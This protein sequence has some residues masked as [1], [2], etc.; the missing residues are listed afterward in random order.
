MKKNFGFGC[1]RLPMIDDIVDREQFKKM[2]D[3]FIKE[4]FNYFDTARVYISGQSEKEIK[5]CLTDRYPRDK[6]ILT[7]KLTASCFQKES[8]I[9]PFFEEQLALTGVEYFDYYL[10]HALN[11]DFYAK[12]ENCNAFKVAKELKKNGKIKHIG[13]SF[14]DKADVLDKILSDHPEI[15]IVQIQFNYADYDDPKIQSKALYDVCEKY[16]K[17]VIVME[18][19]RGGSL[20]NIPKLGKDIFEE[21]G[22][23]CASYAIRFAASYPSVVMVLSG[24]STIGQLRENVGFMKSFKPLNNKERVAID[25]VHKILINQDII[26]C[27]ACRYCVEGCPQKISIPD[28]FTVYNKKKQFNDGNSD[29]NYRNNTIIK[30][31]G[32]AS[33]CIKCGKC[34]SICPQHLPIIENLIKVAS[35]FE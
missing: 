30:G 21:E 29:L 24:M 5:I 3:I 25:K 15:E 32:L 10:M 9:I 12:F 4:G 35:I 18:P 8:E 6:Y 31:L 16:K 7:D 14:H 23:S 20:I 33:D 22:G 26:N 28:L 13:I 19:C 27:T 17:P 2:V 34:E 1:M 11:I